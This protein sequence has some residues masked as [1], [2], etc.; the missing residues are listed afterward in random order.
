MQSIENRK[1]ELIDVNLAISETINDVNRELLILYSFPRIYGHFEKYIETAFIKII[2][3]ILEEDIELKKIKK[4][5]L[6]YLL[7]INFN[8]CN[9][10]SFFSNKYVELERTS[11]LNK[12]KII[13]YIISL[14]VAY[15]FNTYLIKI[16]ENTSDEDLKT[17]IEELKIKVGIITKKYKSRCYLAHGHMEYEKISLNE[18]IIFKDTILICLDLIKEITEKY[19]RNQCYIIS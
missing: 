16:I 19:L 18:I 1:K 10:K 4:E 14:N 13:G 11:Q 8:N 17:K 6:Y 9:N 2:E 5:I 3:T 15:S 12:E 7:F